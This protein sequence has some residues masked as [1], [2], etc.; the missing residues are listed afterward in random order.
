ME[1]G[2]HSQ[3]QRSMTVGGD[4]GDDG[5]FNRSSSRAFPMSPTSSYYYDGSPPVTK[6]QRGAAPQK[7]IELNSEDSLAKKLTTLTDAFNQGK[8]VR[9]EDLMSLRSDNEVSKKI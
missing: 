9:F 2:Y 1:A 3:M 7:P 5:M 4:Y 6:Q 8:L